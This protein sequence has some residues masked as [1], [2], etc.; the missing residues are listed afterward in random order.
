MGIFSAPEIKSLLSLAET[1]SSQ[2]IVDTVP[3][4]TEAGKVAE[5]LR[6]DTFLEKSLSIVILG[7]VDILESEP[8]SFFSLSPEDTA[9]A[10][11]ETFLEI[12]EVETLLEKYLVM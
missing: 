1:W 5:S 10:L 9:T 4:R 7:A 11:G 8:M 3:L 6:E 12:E 2:L